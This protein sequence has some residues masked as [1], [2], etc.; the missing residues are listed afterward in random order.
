VTH[1]LSVKKKIP[2]VGEQVAKKNVGNNKE[3]TDK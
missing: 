1:G 2:S 3:K